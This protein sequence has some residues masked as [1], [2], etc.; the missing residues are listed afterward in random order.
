MVNDLLTYC[1]EFRAFQ[2]YIPNQN[3]GK[4]LRVIH[5]GVD[6]VADMNDKDKCKDKDK[7]NN[8]DSYI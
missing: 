8:N 2:P 7:G 5:M 6:K 1:S 3:L 4:L